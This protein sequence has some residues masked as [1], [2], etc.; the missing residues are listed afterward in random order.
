MQD[1]STYTG[2]PRNEIDWFPRIN[3]EKCKPNKCDLQCVKYCPFS[4]FVQKGGG[5]VEVVNPYDCNVSDESCKFQCPYD[6]ISFPTR[7][8]LK[9]MLRKVRTKYQNREVK[10]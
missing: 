10:K 2:L 6:A 3:Q 1:R 9:M 5:M 4:V 7:E 8:E